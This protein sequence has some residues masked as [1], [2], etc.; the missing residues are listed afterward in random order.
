M[1]IGSAL[2]AGV[3]GLKT[4]SSKLATI[5]DNI[6]NSSTVGYKRYDVQFSS[7]VTGGAA[8]GA[9]SAGGAKS[10]IRTEIDNPGILIGTSSPTD[11]AIGGD[12]FF[13]VSSGVNST[14]FALTR[15][16]SFRPD[17][18][19]NLRNAAGFYL[20][21]F[22]LNPDGSYVNGAV[23]LDTFQD[24]QTVNIAAINGT[25]AATTRIGFSG[26]LPQNGPGPFE[27]AVQYFDEFGASQT[28][29]LNWVSS[30]PNQ[31]DLEI[32]EGPV[33][34]PPAGALTGID[35]N[36]GVP[37]AP[38]YGAAAIG[39][40]VGAINPVTGE[41]SLTLA[42]GQAITLSI[43]AED[44][45]SG[46]TQFAGDFLPETSRDGSG[47]GEIQSLEV[48]DD[49]VLT[50][51]FSSGERRPIFQIPV[52]DVTNANGLRSADGNVFE[53]SRE[54]GSYRLW[55]AG[56]GP[57]G[58]IRGGALENSNVDIAQELTALIETQRAYSSNAS[59]VRTA[60]EMLEEVTRL[61]R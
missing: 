47:L 33:A 48:S 7:L 5:S 23:S 26:N 36:A 21:G 1:S 42:S 44:T 54:A 13:A 52:V 22:A 6:A 8:G 17:E 11:L 15:A 55:G 61:K 16:G 19:G 4:L 18:L 50:A 9:F 30:G 37:G 59:I 20:Q 3:S 24:L 40:I 39:G 25:A 35:F 41:L 29:T 34:G 32:Y 28:L 51:I 57:A 27:T 43:G 49:G 31:Y 56:Q 60:D 45:F 58:T 14:N 38:N 12:G 46:V 53:L 10:S 2:Q